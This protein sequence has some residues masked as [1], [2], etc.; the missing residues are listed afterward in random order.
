MIDVNRIRDGTY[1]DESVIIDI[2]DDTKSVQNFS[3]N[4]TQSQAS[5][6]QASQSQASQSQ[7]SQ[8]QASQSRTLENTNYG[9]INEN[10]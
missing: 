6:S 2:K 7:A 3:E 8:S 4:T 5:Q 9:T 10:V 1:V